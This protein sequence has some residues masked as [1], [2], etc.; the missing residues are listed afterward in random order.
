MTSPIGHSACPAKEDDELSFRERT[1]M[2]RIK[3]NTPFDLR[4]QWE[5]WLSDLPSSAKLVAFAIRIYSDRAGASSNPSIETLQLLT[6]FSRNTVL[7]AIRE[8]GKTELVRKEIGAGRARNS[9]ALVIPQQTL[10]ELANVIDIRS[11]SVIEPL[12]NT[13]S[14]STIAPQGRSGSP[15]EPQG[16]VQPLHHND[17]V[18]QW[19]DRSGSTSEPNLTRDIITKNNPPIVPP[20]EQS[21][22]LNADGIPCVVNG[23]R[24]ALEKILGGKSDVETACLAVAGKIDREGDLWGSLVAEI[25]AFASGLTQK[26]KP[27]RQ[28]IPDTYSEDFEHFWKLYPRA[29]GKAAAFRSWQK[30]SLT[31]KRKAYASLKTQLSTLQAMRKDARGDFCPHPATWINQGRFDDD[32][33]TPASVSRRDILDMSNMPTEKPRP[34]SEA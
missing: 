6:G 7:A 5:V 31:Q 34:R 28:A 29:T 10:S 32:A 27:K 2:Q 4:W 1:R 16:V 21:V 15:D 19:A 25:A 24:Q 23:K 18:V 33:S 3:E 17:V 9:Y 22:W 26:A 8:L 30:L 13:G 11:G 12:R 20:S 14:G